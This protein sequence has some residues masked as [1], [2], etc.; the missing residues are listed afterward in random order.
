MPRCS[1]LHATCASGI[2]NYDDYMG[3]TDAKLG[4]LSSA[5]MCSVCV[6]LS[7]SDIQPATIPA[8]SSE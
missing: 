3:A 5:A 1:L 8:T 2:T 7:F 6:G 4:S